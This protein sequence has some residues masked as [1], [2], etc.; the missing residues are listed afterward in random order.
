MLSDVVR[1]GLYPSRKDRQSRVPPPLPSTDDT[2]VQ[3][4]SPLLFQFLHR[5]PPRVYWDTYRSC[6][7]LIYESLPTLSFKIQY[8]ICRYGSDLGVDRFPRRFGV[9]HC[10]V[11]SRVK[12]DHA[13]SGTRRL[14]AFGRSGWASSSVLGP[15][16]VRPSGP[17]TQTQVGCPVRGL[18][19]FHNNEGGP[20]LRVG[21]CEGLWEFTLRGECNSYSVVLLCPPFFS[22][23]GPAFLRPG[24]TRGSSRMYPRDTAVLRRRPGVG[25]FLWVDGPAPVVGRRN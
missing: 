25:S 12:F 17:H 10:R 8:T 1:S 19:I 14:V 6:G 4:K 5:T 24:S 7:V 13:S 3:R 21:V 18:V 20:C 23:R 9:P 16:R 15:R 11:P 22:C 2:P